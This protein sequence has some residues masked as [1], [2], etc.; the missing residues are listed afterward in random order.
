M[1]FCLF[2]TI[3]IAH[4]QCAIVQ[5]KS[6]LRWLINRTHHHHQRHGIF[7]YYPKLIKTIIIPH[8]EMKKWIHNKWNIISKH[9]CAHHCRKSSNIKSQSNKHIGQI[10][11]SIFRCHSIVLEIFLVFERVCLCDFHQ[12]FNQH[13]QLIYQHVYHTE[14]FWMK[15]KIFM[16]P[17]S[18]SPAEMFFDSLVILDLSG[19][20]IFLLKMDYLMNWNLLATAEFAAQ[21]ARLEM[22]MIRSALFFMQTFKVHL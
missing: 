10:I 4:K 16:E 12:P 17:V 2:V 5:M 22:K 21:I 1:C 7:F 19:W 8:T 15:T 18:T 13:L 6:V 3:N 20:K 11:I 14:K 9:T